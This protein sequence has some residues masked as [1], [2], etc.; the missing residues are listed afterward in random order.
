MLGRIH[1]DLMEAWNES[2]VPPHAHYFA[3][4]IHTRVRTRLR[5][6]I[7]EGFTGQVVCR[8]MRKYR[9]TIRELSQRMGITMKRIR[10]VRTEGLMD[11]LVVRDWLEGISGVDPGQ[12]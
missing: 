5:E 8:L 3:D 6:A 7:D 1:P 4:F 11:P 2:T 9:V 10:E 12:L